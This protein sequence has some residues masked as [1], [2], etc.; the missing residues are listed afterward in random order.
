MTRRHGTEATPPPR[1]ALRSAVRAYDPVPVNAVELG[2][3]PALGRRRAR[4]T[5]D[6]PT[7]SPT[8]CGA[9]HAAGQRV[10]VDRRRPLVHGGG[11]RPTACSSRSTGM[12]PGAPT[13]TSSA[14][15]SRSRPASA[16][17]R[18]NDELAAVGLAMPNL[19]DIDRQSIAG[20][21]ATATHGTGL[22]AR[23]PRHDRRRDG[24]R[25]RAPATSCALDAD[26]DAE[27]LRVARVGARRAGHRHRGDAAVRA[28]VRP[29]RPRDDRAARRRA[30]RPRSS[31]PPPSTTSSS[32]GCRGR[33][34]LPGQAQP[35]HRRAGR[36]RSRRLAYV[37]DKWVGENLAFGLVCR[38]GRRFPS[39]GADGRQ[40][41]QRRRPRSAT[42]IDRSDRVFCSPRRVRFVEMEY[43]MPGRAP[44]RGR[45]AR[46]RP[47]R[48]TCRRPILFPIEVRVSA[49]DDI[50]LSTGFGRTSGW[51][52]VHQYRGMPYEE[53][54]DGVE[55]IMDDYGGRP[56]WGKLHGQRAATLAGRYPQWDD[57]PAARDGSTRT[58]RSPTRTST[59]SSGRDA[60]SRTRCAAVLDAGGGRRRSRLPTAS[61]SC[62]RPT[63][64]GWSAVVAFTGHAYVLADVDPRRADGARRRRL[65][66][67]LAPRR[68]AR[69]RRAGRRDRLARRRA[70]RTRRESAARCAAPRPRRPPAGAAGARTTAATSRCTATTPGWSILGRGLVGR[71]ELAVELLDPAAGGGAGH[72]RRLI[73][74]GLAAVP[75]G[76]PVLGP[77]V[78]GQRRR[79]C[80]RSSP[81]G[82]CRSAPRSSSGAGQPALE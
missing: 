37:R 71:R 24:A 52:A 58:A 5:R 12:R 62:C 6:R 39:A 23:Q 53:Y 7:R 49:A 61:S 66:R 77:G 4:C 25:H 79:R 1:I 82:S 29:P 80:G 74:A 35:A 43:G 2:R 57:F 51:I 54:F 45:A 44:R 75:P 18:L 50:P 19:G 32:T 73:R 76:E 8:S 64:A 55:R 36:A 33:Q 10:K 60:A 27:L 20:A 59:A 56:H 21:I 63:R 17:H 47:R 14:G 30:R 38:V 15:R 46:A 42:S 69:R 34:A 68:A 28:G 16:L 11:R 9:A 26:D 13:S 3:Q 67:R 78:A 40:A 72:G 31:T 65:R 48:G 22:G 41:R 70:R 81:A